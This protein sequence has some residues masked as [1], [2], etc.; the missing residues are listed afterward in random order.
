MSAAIE[1][2]AEPMAVWTVLTDLSSYRDW[3]PLFR[4]AT[5]SIEV[6]KTI[7]LKSVHPASGRIMTVKAKIVAADPGTE[8]RWTAGLPGLVSGE[9]GFA[10]SQVGHRTKLVQSES[11]TGLLVPISGKVLRASQVAFERLNEAIKKRAEAR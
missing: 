8:L 9:H 6:G 11:F 3:N 1:I 7:A 4:D 10:L 2:D 5:G